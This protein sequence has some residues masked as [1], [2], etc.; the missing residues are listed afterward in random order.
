MSHDALVLGG[1]LSGLACARDLRAAG[2]DVLL[3]EAADHAGGVV[4]SDRVD[5]FLFERGPN[6][7]LASSLEF[8]KLVHDVGL[9]ERLVAS[10]PEA[11]LRYLFKDG[12]LIAL[13]TGPLEFLKS[14]VL[15]GRGKRRLMSEPLR[16]FREPDEEPTLEDFLCERLGPEAARTMAGAFVRGVYAAE[17]SQLGAASAFPR[18][19]DLAREHGGLVRGFLA[20][21]KNKKPVPPGPEFRRGSLLSFSEGLRELIERLALEL[22]DR[23]RTKAPVAAIE[24]A[25]SGYEC[26]LES[27]ETI[28]ARQLVLAVPAPVAARLAGPLHA[29]AG[30]I[31]G[32]IEHARLTLVHLGFDASDWASFPSGFGYLVPPTEEGK[33]GVPGVLGT[34]FNSNLFEGRT[35]EGSLSV[36]SFYRGSDI[37]HLAEEGLVETAASDLALGVGQGTAPR[38]RAFRVQPWN[39]VIPRYA[40]GHAARMRELEG[41]L[42]S[43][44]PGFHLAGNYTRGVS[45][46]QVI[47]TGRRVAQ[48]VI[49]AIGVSS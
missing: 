31:L 38:V 12:G 46:E 4:G 20:R 15:S 34:I 1:G 10:R 18:L 47:A 2:H 39:D 28:R 6:T 17:L 9:D 19:W 42:A 41:A 43:S 49:R 27:G 48:D 24:R 16:R 35:P 36:T 40:P 44:L 8:R 32:A 26:R 33:D 22:G 21:R 5:G 45:V 25:D 7:V 14:R 30:S 13:P 37:E 29:G 11:K 3:C 23:L